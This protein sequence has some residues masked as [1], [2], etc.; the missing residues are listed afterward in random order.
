MTTT[1]PPETGEENESSFS[2][3]RFT[4]SIAAPAGAA[5]LSLRR[6]TRARHDQERRARHLLAAHAAPLS[7]QSH[8]PLARG[9]EGRLDHRRYRH[10]YAGH[11]RLVGKDL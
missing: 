11:A 9:G 2:H 8:Q 3:A 7:A 5:A 1:P 6:G 10:Q 4:R